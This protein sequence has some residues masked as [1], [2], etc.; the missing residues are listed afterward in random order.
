[1]LILWI[2]IGQCPYSHN[3]RIENSYLVSLQ[4]D[5]R[6]S[7]DKFPDLFRMSTFIDSI[8]MKL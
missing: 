2:S 4:K 7:L 3:E 8:C 6:G 1:M 5:L